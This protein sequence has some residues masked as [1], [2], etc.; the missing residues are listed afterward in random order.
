M[1]LYAKL[2]PVGS[3]FNN[4]MEQLII[5]LILGL[6]GLTVFRYRNGNRRL[7]YTI[8]F[9]LLLV[10]ISRYAMSWTPNGY[11]IYKVSFMGLGLAYWNRFAEKQNKKVIDWM[12]CVVLLM[13]ALYPINAH[14]FRYGTAN[15]NTFFWLF[16]LFTLLAIV[17]ISV[18]DKW[19]FQESKADY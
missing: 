18:Y 6:G 12:K 11:I 16:T 14:F 13:I 7:I 1:Y 19:E 8:S 17:T 5:E 9:V 15:E 2:N 3:N 10:L 4:S